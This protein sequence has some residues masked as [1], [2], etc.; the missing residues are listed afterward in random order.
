MTKFIHVHGSP[1]AIVD[2]IDFE[3]LSKYSWHLVP[4][5]YRYYVGRNTHINGKNH[6]VLMHREITKC[7]SDMQVHHKDGNTM[8]NTRA[9]LE[10]CSPQQNQ[11]YAYQEMKNA[12]PNR[13]TNG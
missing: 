5:S 7:P 10:I 6:R 1:P 4:G 11:K 12:K 3:T 13:N 8:N 2:D 9:N